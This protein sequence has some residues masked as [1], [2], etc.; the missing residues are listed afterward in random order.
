ML[1]S[2]LPALKASRPNLVA[3]LRG[4]AP[5]ARVGGRR[6]ALRDGLVVAPGGADRRAAGGRG[7]AAAQP[8]RV[9]ARRRRLRAARPGRHRLRH[10]HG[11]LRAGARAGV[12]AH[13]A[14]ARRARCPASPVRP[15]CR[16]P[17]RSPSISTRQEMRIDNRT[18]VEGQRGEIIEN[19][20]V[21]PGYLA[22]LGVRL[23]D[24]RDFDATDTEGAPDV[25]VV[26]ETMARRFWPD[27]SAAGPHRAERRAPSRDLPHGRRARRSQAARR[28]RTAVAVRL[29]RGG[30][31]AEP[32]Q[33]PAG[34]HQRRC[35]GA[36][37]RDAARAAGDGAGAG[38]HGRQHDGRSTWRRR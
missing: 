31:A 20:V 9:A 5:A 8:R 29:L 26:N 32:L 38:V 1:A 14:G 4:E 21:S 10:R 35:R 13:G 25:A 19:V 23:L 12:L 2:L 7:A 18:Y 27:E 3:D 33:L 15:R 34:A 16:R 36:G 30:A 37:H 22:T 11:A 24:G 6:W 17:C 28:A